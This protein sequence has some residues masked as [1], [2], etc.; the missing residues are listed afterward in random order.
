MGVRVNHRISGL[1]LFGFLTVATT[2]VA[3][4]SEVF[5]SASTVD[6]VRRQIA[7]YVDIEH[8]GGA[9]DLD[10]HDGGLERA[11]TLP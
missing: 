7:R 3:A 2:A 4:E 10:V 11:G 8:D 1:I 9:V 6:E 5:K